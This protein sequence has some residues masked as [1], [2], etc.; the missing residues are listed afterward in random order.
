MK[1]RTLNSGLL[2][3]AAIIAAF[4][5]F[6]FC[7]LPA[8]GPAFLAYHFSRLNKTIGEFTNGELIM[9]T[10]VGE[11]VFSLAIAILDVSYL[12]EAGW[13]F[14]INFIP[15]I[16]FFFLGLYKEKLDEKKGIAI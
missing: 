6:I 5:S 14:L 2:L 13:L 4:I 16:I 10:L 9:I 7:L 8:I 12:Q 11:A 1:I 3:P 15:T